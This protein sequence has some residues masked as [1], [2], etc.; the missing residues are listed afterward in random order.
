MRKART[1]TKLPQGVCIAT[2]VS[3]DAS[4]A[5]AAGEAVTPTAHPLEPEATSPISSARSVSAPTSP[6]A[7]PAPKHRLLDDTAVPPLSLLPPEPQHAPQAPHNPSSQPPPRRGFV[8]G[9]VGVLVL[10]IALPLRLL[11]GRA[12]KSGRTD[13]AALPP[14]AP[15][16]RS[17]SVRSLDRPRSPGAREHDI[18]GRRDVLGE[19]V[20]PAARL[21]LEAAGLEDG[22]AAPPQRPPPRQSRLAATSARESSALDGIAAALRTNGASSLADNRALLARFALTRNFEVQPTVE[23]LL[24]YHGWRQTMRLDKLTRTDVAAELDKRYVMWLP[25]T[26]DDGTAPPCSADAAAGRD[27]DGKPVLYKC[28]AA[29]E[30]AP[31][32]DARAVDAVHAWVFDS[33]CRD[34]DADTSA[35]AADTFSVLLDLTSAASR[36]DVDAFRAL[37]AMLKLGFR[38]RL[39]RMVIYPAGRL[40]RIVFAGVKKFMGKGTPQKVLMLAAHERAQLLAL[41]PR[42]L[43]P[44]HLGGRS[45]VVAGAQRSILR[46]TRSDASMGS[47]RISASSLAATAHQP[48]LSLQ[49]AGQEED[50][51]VE[52]EAAL[53]RM[54]PLGWTPRESLKETLLRLAVQGAIG[55]VFFDYGFLRGSRAEARHLQRHHNAPSLVVAAPPPSQGPAAVVWGALL[56][57]LRFVGSPWRLFP[58]LLHSLGGCAVGA[59][60]LGTPRVAGGALSGAYFLGRLVAHVE[61]TAGRSHPSARRAPLERLV[62]RLPLPMRKRPEEQRARPQISIADMPSAGMVDLVGAAA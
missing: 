36:F 48:G 28:M 39:H 10:P 34:M 20:T 60:L 21:A 44:V 52:A 35:G 41:F 58:F 53:P 26:C 9:V 55:S 7:S 33:V 22:G 38:G 40:E 23:L 56:A 19:K 13:A 27:F 6:V 49:A 30:R 37:G 11:L 46:R 1:H 14:E 18:P 5:S 51:D 32:G 4:N 8:R 31:R 29:W 61:H 47:A 3:S 16:R 17:S 50:E 25:A 2:G 59:T 24:Q 57:S 54:W 45:L 15:L 42:D 12:R 62:M 43:L